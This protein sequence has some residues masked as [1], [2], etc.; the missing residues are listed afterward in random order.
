MSLV[1]I[2]NRSDDHLPLIEACLTA[3]Y[4]LIDPCSIGHGTLGYDW[5]G[6]VPQAVYNGIRL[7]KVTA[8]LCRTL[9]S[10]MVPDNKRIEERYRAYCRAAQ[11]KSVSALSIMFEDAKWVSPY[12]AMVRAAHKPLQLSVARQVG[13][14]VPETIITSDPQAARAF[15]D[16]HLASIVKPLVPQVA[17]NAKKRTVFFATKLH[18]GQALNYASLP[19]APL[20]FQQAVECAADIRVVVVGREVFAAQIIVDERDNG[21]IRD[22]RLAQFRGGLEM[23]AYQLPAATKE[24]CIAVVE[25]LGLVFGIIDLILD[26]K[27]R[28][29]FLECNTTGAWGLIEKLTSQPIGR[30]VA[31]LLTT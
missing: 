20:I 11:Q 21:A 15:V 12:Y 6:T 23:S 18:K 24:A 5:Q 19:L 7:D 1:I 10:G 30:A 2:A 17:V 27:G 8:V 13:L 9:L 28:L 31:K 16:S 29:W 14:A 25:K 3:P 26:K 22:W 4:T